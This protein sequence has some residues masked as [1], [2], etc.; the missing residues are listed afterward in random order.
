ISKNIVTDLL[1]EKLNFKGLIFTDALNMKGASNFK[2]HGEIDLEAFL[3]GNDIL[4]FPENVPV[5]IEK[6][7]EALSNGKLSKKR[8]EHSVKKIL[9]YKYKAGLHNYKPIDTTHLVQEL[10]RSEDEALHYK[11]MENALTVLKNKGEIFP[12]KNIDTQKIAY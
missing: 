1:Q 12:I 6:F 5:A 2:S 8:L 4:L 10:N 11:L 7:K 3:A 9:K